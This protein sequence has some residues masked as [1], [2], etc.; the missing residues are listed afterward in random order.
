MLIEEAKGINLGL[1]IFAIP[2]ILVFCIWACVSSFCL[3]VCIQQI[4]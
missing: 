2:K 4:L 1:C 3:N